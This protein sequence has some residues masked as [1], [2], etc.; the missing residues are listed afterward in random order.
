MKNVFLSL[1]L[2][3]WLPASAAEQPEL[4]QS[5]SGAEAGKEFR[6]EV[7][8]ARDTLAHVAADEKAGNAAD[9]RCKGDENIGHVALPGGPSRLFALCVAVPGARPVR[10]ILTEETAARRLV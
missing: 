10:R 9:Q 3:A 7:S 1:I 6:L 4:V 8:S 5:A 2:A